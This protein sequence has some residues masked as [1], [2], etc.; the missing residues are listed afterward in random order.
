MLNTSYKVTRVPEL[1]NLFPV[2]CRHCREVETISKCKV[3]EEQI[4]ALEE[5]VSSLPLIQNPKRKIVL[6][7]CSKDTVSNGVVGSTNEPKDNRESTNKDA[8]TLVNGI[9]NKANPTH[10]DGSKEMIVNDN[11]TTG[12]PLDTE[13]MHVNCTIDTGEKDRH[14]ESV[15]TLMTNSSLRPE[16]VSLTNGMTTNNRAHHSGNISDM[17]LIRKFSED[18]HCSFKCE[19]QLL[20]RTS[21]VLRSLDIL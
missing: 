10:E 16:V 7:L 15:A 17:E 11:S 13:S 19:K 6:K 1:P 9:T 12:D 14:P 4:K 3:N 2:K 20:A 8:V 21:V 5:E 18:N